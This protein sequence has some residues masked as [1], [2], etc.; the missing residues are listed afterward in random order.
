[1]L[2]AVVLL[3]RSYF[4]ELLFEI[5]L[6][7]LRFASI[8]YWRVLDVAEDLDEKLQASLKIKYSFVSL[9]QRRNHHLRLLT[10]HGKPAWIQ[11]DL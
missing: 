5:V 10:V 6:I 1:M 8:G 2:E 7:D 3:E 4:G 9:N 11:C